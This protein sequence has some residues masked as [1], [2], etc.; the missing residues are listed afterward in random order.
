MPL[1]KQALN[2]NFAQGLDTKSDPWQVAPGAMLELVNSVFT[3]TGQLTKRNGFQQLANLPLAANHVTTYKGSLLTLQNN[4]Q[5][6]APNLNGWVNK[7]NYYQVLLASVPVVR[8]ATS[9]LTVD[10]AVS[11]GVACSVWVDADGSK[12]YQVSDAATGEVIQ[13]ATVIASTCNNPRVFALGSYFVITYTSGTNLYYKAISQSSPT[14]ITSP[15]LLSAQVNAT[16]AAYD[17]NVQNNFLYLAFDGGDIGGAIRITSLDSTLVQHFTR[18]IPGESAD[19]I[20]VDCDNNV[21]IWVSY[22]KNSTST[23]KN[24]AVNGIGLDVTVPTTV[25]TGVTINHLTCLAFNSG[26]T[27]YCTSYYQNT[28]YYNGSSGPRSDFLSKVTCT[29]TGGVVTVNTPSVMSRSVG[30]ASKAF[31][32]NG[33]N[34]MLVTYGD[35]SDNAGVGSYQPSYFLME[36][37]GDIVARLAYSNG[38]GYASSFVLPNVWMVGSNAYMGYLLRDLV[39]SVNKDQNAQSHSNIYAQTGINLVEFNIGTEQVNTAEIGGSLHLTGGLMWQYDGVKPVEHGFNVFPE[40]ITY[41]QGSGGAMKA[42]AYFYQVTYEWTDNAGQI[43][44]SAPSIPLSVDLTNVTP[45]PVTTTATFANASTTITVASASGLIVGQ[46]ITNTTNPAYFQA[47]TIITAISGTTVTINYPTTHASTG[48]PGDTITTSD[49]LSVTL[50][51][52]Y[53]RLTYKTTPNPVRIVVYRWSTDLQTYYQIS[54]VINPTINQVNTI[55]TTTVT[56]TNA[57]TSIVGNNL[58]YTTGGVLENTASPAAAAMSLFKSRLFIIDGEDR[59][60]LWYS[61]PVLENTPVEMTDLQT[62]YVAPTISSQGSTGVMRCLFPMDDKLLIFKRD[63]IYYL[64]GN[65]PDVTG[66]NNDYTDPVFIT[67]T[68]GCSNPDSI[69]NMPNGVMFQSD[70]GIWLLGRD[71]ST[72]YIGAPVEK[73]NSDTVVSAFTVPGTNQVRF[74]LASGITLMY[75]YYFNQWGSF[76][77]V[78]AVSGVIYNNLHTYINQYSQTFQENP[79]SYVDGST[80]VVMSFK[81]AWFKTAGLQGFQRAYYFMLLGQYYS[82]HTLSL[83]IAYDYDPSATQVATISPVN[84]SGTYGDDPLY[85]DGSPYGGGTQ[86]E[87]WRVFLTRQKCQSFQIS[88]QETYDSSIGPAAGAGLT[89]SGINLVVGVK[90]GWNT[91]KPSLSVS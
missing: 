36:D 1:Q 72:N 50:T 35:T 65:G 83:G 13:S 89:L 90:K 61:K 43:H 88:F 51:I 37:D 62:I 16:T 48:S 28:S 81:S 68:V 33:L 41:T 54:S 76:Q 2:L 10:S 79:G 22:Y 3:K 55:D 21:N 20:A 80:P 59:N 11:N 64:T 9:Q 60:L 53:L 52:P 4:V 49:T 45:T 39:Q 19:I 34:Y 29:N 17:G 14:T 84:Y 71:F 32:M 42:Q 69:V 73:Y 40:D 44:R 91:L 12:Y 70:K 86:V 56:D 57:F 58:L 26:I 87:Q 7:G 23:L 8:K 74:L 63:A 25:A 5:L 85:G 75:D 82:P 67:S 46:R 30:L 77:G 18:A 6:Y 78:P 47:G 66:A 27:T 15:F 31:T 24:L 38:A